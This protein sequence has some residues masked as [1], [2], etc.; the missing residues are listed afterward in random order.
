MDLIGSIRKSFDYN[1][2]IITDT[3]VTVP[4][5]PLTSRKPFPKEEVSI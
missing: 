3:A 4:T 5:Y 2:F 1:R